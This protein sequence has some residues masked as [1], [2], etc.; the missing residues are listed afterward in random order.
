MVGAFGAGLVGDLAVIMIASAVAILL[1]KRLRQPVVLGYLLAGM[2]IGPGSGL[3]DIGIDEG[4]IAAF[5]DLGV[6][7]VLLFI[8]MEFDLRQ[9]RAIGAPAIVIG[10]VEVTVMLGVGYALGLAMGLDALSAVYLGAL[11]SISSTAV[12][13]KILTDLDLMQDR[14]TRLVFGILVV[15]DFAAVILLSALSGTSNLATQGVEGILAV[16]VSVV[17]FFFGT[18]FIGVLLIPRAF[19]RLERLGSDEVLTI[20]ALGLS[21]G[22]ALVATVLGYS[23]AMGAFLAGVLIGESGVLDSI[24]PRFEPIR[25]LFAAIFFVSVGMLII[26]AEFIGLLLPISLVCAVFLVGKVAAAGGATYLLGYGGR[27]GLAVGARLARTG[28][29]SFIIGKNGLSTGAM[30]PQ[31]Y[32][33]IAGVTLITTFVSPFLVRGS[34]RLYRAVA[35]SL[36]F[37]LDRAGSAYT[38]WISRARSSSRRDPAVHQVYR[39][40]GIRVFLTAIFLLIVSSAT[41]AFTPYAPGIA[42]VLGMTDDLVVTA[43]IGAAVAVVV[44]P[45]WVLGRLGKDLIDLTMQA[46]GVE[47]SIGRTL[48]RTAVQTGLRAVIVAGILGILFLGLSPLV[49]VAATGANL[50]ALVVGLAVVFAVAGWPVLHRTKSLHRRFEDIFSNAPAP[51]GAEGAPQGAAGAAGGAAAGA[52]GSPSNLPRYLW[53]VADAETLAEYP[54]PAASPLLGAALGELRIR[55]RTGARVVAVQHGQEMQTAPPPGFRLHEGDV[56]LIV[57]TLADLERFEVLLGRAGAEIER[58]SPQ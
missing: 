3:L 31:L 2:A 15:E 7:F 50:P 43:L 35:G 32:P 48:A 46:S 1:F 10:T 55:G 27:D 41:V 19:H 29:F 8:G 57:G 4:D 13:I 23:P 17:L 20:A 14:A 33:L 45:V 22:V 36:P 53:A 49:V 34:S 12:T 16:I 42:R 39:Q 11:V 40:T 51:D 44:Y 24:R 38:A 5:A 25:D 37:G 18:I 47:R 28:E 52:G 9:L 21:F 6:I 26:P 30:A 54:V 58:D 56:V